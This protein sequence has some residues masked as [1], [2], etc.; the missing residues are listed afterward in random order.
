MNLKLWNSSASSEQT[1]RSARKALSFFQSLCESSREIPEYR[2][3]NALPVSKSSMV[4]PKIHK[5]VAKLLST[6]GKKAEQ[7][8]IEEL[9]NTIGMEYHAMFMLDVIKRHSLGK[10]VLENV[11]G[12]LTRIQE[13]L[14]DPR[15]FLGVIG[16]F[17]TGKSTL[18]NALLRDSLLCTDR[19]IDGKQQGTTSSATLIGYGKLDAQIVFQNRSTVSFGGTLWPKLMSFLGL[20]SDSAY[21]EYLLRFLHRYT[22]K[23]EMAEQVAQV[24]LYHPSDQLLQGLV[25]VDTPGTNTSSHPRHK[26]VTLNAIK[27]ICDAA[28]IL[29]DAKVP[30]PETLLEFLGWEKLRPVLHRC[31]FV[32]THLDEANPKANPKEQKRLLETIQKRIKNFLQLEDPVILPL[33]P[34]IFFDPDG[35]IIKKE[36]Q[37]KFLEEFLQGEEKL[38][39][40]L[41]T[42]KWIVPLEALA[43]SMASLLVQLQSK[44][45]RRAEEYRVQHK[46]L[47]DNKIPDMASF[48]SEKQEEMQEEFLNHSSQ[49]IEDW[50]NELDTCA[51]KVLQKIQSCIYSVQSKDDLNN[52][53]KGDRIPSFIRWGENECKN[54]LSELS[55][56]IHNATQYQQ[57]K[58]QE[59]FASIYRS[60]ATL[61][62]LLEESYSINLQENNAFL[63]GTISLGNND[64]AS[65]FDEQTTGDNWRKGGL[66]GAGAYIGTCIAPG[67]GTIIGAGL[68]FLVSL[69]WS[70]SLD[71]LKEESYGKIVPCIRNGFYE[72]K[73]KISE[74]QLIEDYVSAELQTLYQMLWKYQEVYERKVQEMIERDEKQKKQLMDLSYL[75]EQDKESLQS[76][77]GQLERIQKQLRS[78]R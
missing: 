23:D 67:V 59:K 57:Q 77:M 70:P 38:Y 1:P 29:I 43:R 74:A 62:G 58:F 7:L 9:K 27:E 45:D 48:I 20:L 24:N 55:E 31:I 6:E 14:D 11:Q 5:Q 3:E 56:K 51:T 50:Q 15:F 78:R 8:Q 49:H 13:R 10:E 40:I 72:M 52:V 68:G 37:K 16:E 4:R 30:V 26:Q 63:S 76:R 65:Y 35:T 69:I 73:K 39:Q 2:E 47:E 34:I 60:L 42:N 66:A 54:S 44:L 17:S 36:N 33:S 64:A 32:V 28:I 22:A 71:K 41:H 12:E 61:G 53:L 18:I 25:I 46:A 75:I 19:W 21:K